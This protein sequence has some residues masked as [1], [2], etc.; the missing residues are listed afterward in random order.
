[1]ARSSGHAAGSR[2]AAMWWAVG[3]WE[4]MFKLQLWRFGVTVDG[5]CV[6][7]VSLEDSGTCEYMAPEIWR[8]VSNSSNLVTSP[9]LTCQMRRSKSTAKS[10]SGHM[11][12]YAR[13]PLGAAACAIG[14]SALPCVP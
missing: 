7:I 5:V 9:L 10:M 2:H 4:R 11:A 12:W 3:L 13:G 14:P 6:G 8:Q 1:M